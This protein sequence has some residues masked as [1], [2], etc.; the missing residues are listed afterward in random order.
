[1]AALEA[2]IANLMAPAHRGRMVSTKIP[3]QASNDT[4]SKLKRCFGGWNRGITDV[5]SPTYA[6]MRAAAATAAA[7]ATSSAAS[8][9]TGRLQAAAAVCETGG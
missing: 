3:G 7:I 4:K 5:E 2:L 1:M 9:V 6:A 8:A